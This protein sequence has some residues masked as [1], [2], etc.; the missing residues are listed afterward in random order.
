MHSAPPLHSSA[1]TLCTSPSGGVDEERATR[2]ENPEG[3]MSMGTRDRGG[4]EK[5]SA[6]TT[7]RPAMLRRS[8]T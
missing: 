6:A 4:R 2:A 8:A 1:K 3:V 7:N 5:Y